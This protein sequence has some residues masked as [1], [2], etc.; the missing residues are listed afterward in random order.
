MAGVSPRLSALPWLLM[1]LDTVHGWMVASVMGEGSSVVVV[2]A[3]LRGA[4]VAC[5]RI[6]SGSS[7]LLVLAPVPAPVRV[8]VLALALVLVL[9]LA[10][11]LV[12]GMLVWSS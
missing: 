1:Y 7:Q 9:V 11:A 2:V 12:L 4:L 3:L 10:L 5:R 6:L 8:L